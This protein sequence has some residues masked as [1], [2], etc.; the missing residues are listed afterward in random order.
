V[1]IAGLLP[2]GNDCVAAKK[3]AFEHLLFEDGFD[4]LRGEVVS[5]DPNE[6]VPDFGPSQEI[7]G[8]FKRLFDAD[9]CLPDPLDFLP[10]FKSPFR[11]KLSIGDD[12]F[13]PFRF[14]SP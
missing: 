5:V 12:N 9:L 4:P 10:T 3:I 13:N 2:A 14:E 11:V 6:T 1:W 8:Y 7:K